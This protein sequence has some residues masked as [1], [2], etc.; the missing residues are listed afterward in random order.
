M[1]QT[2]NKKLSSVVTWLLSIFLIVSGVGTATML[3][4]EVAPAG[5]QLREFFEALYNAKYI[6]VW[7]G[8]FKF[9]TGILLLIPKTNKLAPIMLIAYSINILL[10]TLFVGTR[11]IPMAVMLLLLNLFLIYSNWDYYKP[12]FETYKIEAMKRT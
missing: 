2:K 6:F 9:I 11:F 4:P 1:K 5:T 3:N 7:I 12:I 10:F 8:V